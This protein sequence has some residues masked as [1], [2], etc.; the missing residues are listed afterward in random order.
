MPKNPR[1]IVVEKSDYVLNKD[2][3]YTVSKDWFLGRM[4]KEKK[5]MDALKKCLERGAKK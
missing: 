3:T 1:V 2:G 4:S 5:L